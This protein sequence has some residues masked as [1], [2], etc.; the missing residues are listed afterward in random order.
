MKKKLW[1]IEITAEK[2][3]NF[4]FEDTGELN[5]TC[6]CCRCP[7]KFKLVNLTTDKHITPAINGWY[8]EENQRC[9]L[10][11]SGIRG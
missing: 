10:R 11:E 7:V 4:L 9:E 5:T 1:T 6:P 3:D 2:S 8:Y